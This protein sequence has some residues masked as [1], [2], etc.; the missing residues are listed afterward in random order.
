MSSRKLIIANKRYSSW[1][2][3]PW[4]FLTHHGISFEEIRIPLFTTDS[5]ARLREYSPSGFVPV[6]YE[7]DLVI[8]DSLAILE[9]VA[10][11]YPQTHGWPTAVKARAMARSVSA[12]MH[13]G[14][15]ALRST[16][17]MDLKTRY[18]WQD[19]GPA[20][21]KEIARIETI[22]TQCRSEFGKQGPWLFGEFTIA[23]AMFA[24][25][26]TR[27][28]T[29]SVPISA[30]S[31]AYVDT[32]MQLPAFKQWQAAALAESEVIEQYEKTDRKRL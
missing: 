24:P 7:N 17:T 1:S 11:T 14:F 25:V 4:L 9:Y 22:W 2:M 16:L 8:W 6:F 26:A 15:A 13:S 23:D 3:R 12:E 10:E 29:Y 32:V 28:H 30:T 27:F 21:A 5:E 31:Q 20:V 19:S 18:Q